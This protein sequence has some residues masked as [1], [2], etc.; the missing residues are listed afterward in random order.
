MHPDEIL[1]QTARII[2]DTLECGPV[3]IARETQ[4]MHVRGW[5]SLSHTMILM[6]LEDGFGVRL[7][8]ERVL[9]LGTVGELVDLIAE[10]RATA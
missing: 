7:P 8:M 5:D 4:A 2:R 3:P 10:I 1:R 6:Q 9:R